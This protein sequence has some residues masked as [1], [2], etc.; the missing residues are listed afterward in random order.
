MSRQS[1][2]LP[3]RRLLL[4]ILFAVLAPAA[5]AEDWQTVESH[6]Y[7]INL[8][9][10]HAGWAHFILEKDGERF[11]STSDQFLSIRRGPD[12]GSIHRGGRRNAGAD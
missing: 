7:A 3:L 6:W 11:R 2:T 10:E 4:A 8:E 1:E 12:D 5:V 9:G